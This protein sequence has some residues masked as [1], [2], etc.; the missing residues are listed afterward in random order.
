MYPD[1]FWTRFCQKKISIRVKV[2]FISSV[3]FGMAAHMFMMTNKLPNYDDVHCLL[4][5]YGSGIEFGRWMLFILGNIMRRTIGNISLPWINGLI[6]IVILSITSVVVVDVLEIRSKMLCCL[7]SAI[8]VSFPS[9]T[10]TLF[11]MYTAIYYCMAALM[12]AL[13]IKCTKDCKYGYIYG[14]FMI[15]AGIGIYQ[16][17]FAWG[18]SLALLLLISESLK[19]SV[20][21]V[22]IFRLGI[23]Y[24]IVLVC[25]LLIYIVCVQL[26][27]PIKGGELSEY[28]G[29]SQMTQFSIHDAPGLILRTYQNYFALMYKKFEGL[30]GFWLIRISIIVLHVIIGILIFYQIRRNKKECRILEIA[31]LIGMIL[32]FPIAVNLIYIM[33][34]DSYIYSIMLFSVVSIYLLMGVVL[35]RIA[36]GE[37]ISI[38]CNWIGCILLFVVAICQCQF[39]N[40][41]YLSMNLQY[42]QASSYFTTMV[43]QIKSLNGYKDT[44]RVAFIGDTID[45]LSYSY[46]HEFDEYT[47]GGRGNE[48]VNLYSRNDFLRHYLGYQQEIV[49]NADEWKN[50]P[51]VMIMPLYPDEGSMKIIDDV[52]IVKLEN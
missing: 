21:G 15:A 50:R 26:F 49:G 12:M 41:Q 37:R 44:M 7:I 45:D 25:G 46:N 22:A 42:E 30:N 24:L 36:N 39:S 40:I 16:A 29:L 10:G 34:P 23:K 20:K 51:E 43:T 52:I 38:I 8:M 9:V 32:A 13:A 3:I 17:Y 1:E 4:D 35:E 18:V 14:V 27:L 11:F 47:M 2:T 31:E 19:N 48:L 5:D 33:S 28:Q 6:C